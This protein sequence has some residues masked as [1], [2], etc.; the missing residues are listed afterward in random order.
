MNRLACDPERVADLL[1]GPSSPPRER[2]PISFDAL[3][4]PAQGNR[5]AQA[6]R[7]IVAGNR[8]RELINIHDVSL[9]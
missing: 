2:D 6:E 9:A 1:P 7:R 5:G 3:G 8:L 4:Q